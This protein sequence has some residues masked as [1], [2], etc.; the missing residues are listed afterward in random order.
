MH[1]KDEMLDH[2]TPLGELFEDQLSAADMVIINKTDLVD[3]A[4]L[5]KVE[6]NIRA[7]WAAIAVIRGARTASSP[8]ACRPR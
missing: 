2:E 7:G 1:R 6:A 3:A 5:E 4:L 8:R